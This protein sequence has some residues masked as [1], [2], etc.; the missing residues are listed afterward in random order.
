MRTCVLFLVCPLPRVRCFL[1]RLTVLLPALPDVHLSAQ[2]E[3]QVQPPVRLPL[4]DRGH[5]RLRDTPH[6]TT[7]SGSFFCGHSAFQAR[8][9]RRTLFP[10]PC[11]AC[12]G[13]VVCQAA[14]SP[15]AHPFFLLFGVCD[16]FFVFL[17]VVVDILDPGGHRSSRQPNI[18]VRWKGRAVQAHPGLSTFGFRG[19]ARASE[20]APKHFEIDLM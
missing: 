8:P 19:D 10:P 12:L 13:L 14:K 9:A 16:V 20:Q 6:T 1:P 7:V 5:I 4:G 18:Q 17:S 11:F 3:V 2:R 15:C